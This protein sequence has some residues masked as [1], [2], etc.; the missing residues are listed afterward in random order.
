MNGGATDSVGGYAYIYESSDSRG[1]A[2]LT[3]RV[4]GA[5]EKQLQG[6]LEANVNLKDLFAACLPACPALHLMGLV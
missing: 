3:G 5:V 2:L 4:R 6:H 1:M